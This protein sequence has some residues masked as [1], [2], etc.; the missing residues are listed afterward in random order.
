MLFFKSNQTEA[1]NEATMNNNRPT[2]L[3]SSTFPKEEIYVFE[4]TKFRDDDD[5]T[6]DEF[7]SLQGS[8]RSEP[9]KKEYLANDD[10]DVSSDSEV[11]LVKSLD[12]G[13]F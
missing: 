12:V 11:I 7:T 5:L 9:N 6:V 2:N 13:D 3:K 4:E 8:S 1:T 10:D